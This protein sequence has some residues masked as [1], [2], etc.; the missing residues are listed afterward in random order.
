[1]YPCRKCGICCRCVSHTV[2]GSLLANE[3]GICKYLDEETNLCTI[4][5][6][7]PLFCNVDEY[8]KKYYSSK[9]TLEEFYKINLTSC[10]ILYKKI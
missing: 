1:M 4:Y 9:M 5:N 10:K 7:R 8:Y 3:N 6:Q 2:L